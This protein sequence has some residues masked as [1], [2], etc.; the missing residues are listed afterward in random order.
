VYVVHEPEE[1]FLVVA[2]AAPEPPESPIAC[3]VALITRSNWS[4][5]QRGQQ[6]SFFSWEFRTRISKISL[7]FEHLNS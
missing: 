4:D 7:H 6:M 5:W 3:R 1:Q 2:C